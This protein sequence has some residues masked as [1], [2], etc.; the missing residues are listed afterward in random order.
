MLLAVGNNPTFLFGY[1]RQYFL[2][3][4][5]YIIDFQDAEELPLNNSVF[6]VPGFLPMCLFILHSI[7]FLGPNLCEDMSIIHA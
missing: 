4:K 7:C 6:P 3:I 1:I 5:L 2:P